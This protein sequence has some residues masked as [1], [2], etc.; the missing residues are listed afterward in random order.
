MSQLRSKTG[1]LNYGDGRALSARF[2]YD[3]DEAVPPD[4]EGIDPERHATWIED[5]GTVG[6]SPAYSANYDAVDWGN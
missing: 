2:Y 4:R 5:D 1:V 6:A 3:D